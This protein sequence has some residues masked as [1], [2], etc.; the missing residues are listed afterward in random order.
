MLNIAM[1]LFSKDHTYTDLNIKKLIAPNNFIWFLNE[2]YC[3][4]TNIRYACLNCP[5]EEKH[6]VLK[7]TK[8]GFEIFILT[9]QKLEPT[10]GLMILCTHLVTCIN[11]ITK[12]KQF[13]RRVQE[14]ICAYL[15]RN[16]RALK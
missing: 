16:L 9:W 10:C 13:D 7:C 1:H 6:S 5:Y 12:L 14:Y 11:N 2:K 15:D 8:K 4:K 3:D